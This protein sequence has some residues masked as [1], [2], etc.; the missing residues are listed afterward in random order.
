MTPD[1]VSAG[2]PLT[3]GA[4]APDPWN[5]NDMHR[6]TDAILKYA[7]IE[8]PNKNP[9]HASEFALSETAQI[10]AR[11]YHDEQEKEK[12][13]S[14]RSSKYYI[15]LEACLQNLHKLGVLSVGELLDP[16]N[17]T[18]YRVYHRT[19]LL[20]NKVCPAIHKEPDKLHDVNSILTQ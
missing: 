4:G 12:A 5:Q 14:N 8:A 2:V 18:G 7:C 13:I 19:L 1:P 3:S 10:I 17:G 16:S 6:W 11:T 9:L 20:T 15:L